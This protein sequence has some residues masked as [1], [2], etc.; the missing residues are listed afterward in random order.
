MSFTSIQFVNGKVVFRPFK[1][2]MGRFNKQ[3]PVIRSVPFAILMS[4]TKDLIKPY[5]S[6][7]FSV[8]FVELKYLCFSVNKKKWNAS[9]GL[10]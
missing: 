9:H 4:V 3:S 8:T 1:T 2:G 10:I 6:I 5:E 7:P